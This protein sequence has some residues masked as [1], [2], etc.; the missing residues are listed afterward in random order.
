MIESREKPRSGGKNP[1]PLYIFWAVEWEILQGYPANSLDE[2]SQLISL[3][4]SY[5]IFGAFFLFNFDD[6]LNFLWI[7]I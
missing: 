5:L 2:R 4:N 6:S 3:R 1:V 7:S